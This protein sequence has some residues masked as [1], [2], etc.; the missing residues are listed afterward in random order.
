MCSASHW[1]N[2]LWCFAVF[3]SFAV[4]LRETNLASSRLLERG[5][6][7]TRARH[8]LTRVVKWPSRH[9]C[10]DVLQSR[11]GIP[12]PV[13][14][15]P[16]CQGVRVA[17]EGVVDLAYVLQLALE[18]REAAWTRGRTAGVVLRGAQILIVERR[19]VIHGTNK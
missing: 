2:S 9:W 17:E 5:G 13:K 3:A 15:A 8:R 1:P 14:I 6:T 12:R 11:I 16:A 4:D 19:G 10:I 18:G 7:R